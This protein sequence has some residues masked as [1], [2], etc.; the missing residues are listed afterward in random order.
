[1]TAFRVTTWNLENLFRSGH[2]FGPR[3][4]DEYATK[5]HSLA[6]TILSIDPDVLAVQEVGGAAPLS[7]LVALLEERYPYSILS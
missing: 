6:Q 1:M 5:L 3:T 2:E 4:A 7:D